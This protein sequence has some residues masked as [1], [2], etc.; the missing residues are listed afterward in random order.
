MPGEPS[1]WVKK[2][3]SGPQPGQQ[4]PE[5]R[6][7]RPD[8]PRS[9]HYRQ[10]NCTALGCVAG[11]AVF[12]ESLPGQPVAAAGNRALR[13][14]QRG[15]DRLASELWDVPAELCAHR[16]PPA[17]FCLRFSPGTAAGLP[18]ACAATCANSLFHSCPC[19]NFCQELPWLPHHLHPQPNFA[20]DIGRRQGLLLLLFF[21]FGVGGA[22]SKVLKLTVHRPLPS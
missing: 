17:L 22:G 2:E 19:P 4:R 12:P 6:T 13:R 10:E 5:T 7:T 11:C 18:P 20:S 21:F 8:D 14:A 3:G 16:R 1:T 9:P 15:S